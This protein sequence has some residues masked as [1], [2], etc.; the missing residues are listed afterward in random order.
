MTR[1]DLFSACQKY[2]GNEIDMQFV[3]ALIA[4]VERRRLS[5]QRIAR[6]SVFR[7]PTGPQLRIF[8]RYSS[9]TRE[10]RFDQN[11]TLVLD[12]GKEGH[13][14]SALPMRIGNLI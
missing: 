2:L 13:T 8:I 5:L 6:V 4:K 10:I 3:D 11:L 1:K 12:T 14:E 9:S 7:S